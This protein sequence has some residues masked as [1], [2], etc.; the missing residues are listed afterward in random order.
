MARVVGWS[1]LA[2]L[3]VPLALLG[4][5][6]LEGGVW[7]APKAVILF[8]PSSILLLATSGFERTPFALWMHVVAIVLNAG[9]YAILGLLGYWVYHRPWH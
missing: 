6:Q 2:G 1:V 4:I 7:S 3:M 9:W 8:W 5:A